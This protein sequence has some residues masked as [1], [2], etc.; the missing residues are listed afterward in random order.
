MQKVVL[1][2]IASYLWFLEFDVAKSVL[3]FL[4]L[5]CLL[6]FIVMH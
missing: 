2:V 1:I 6:I 5:H 4:L 3:D